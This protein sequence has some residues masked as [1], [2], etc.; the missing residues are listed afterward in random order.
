M[1]GPGGH[2][3]AYHPAAAG[4][5]RESPALVAA[6]KPSIPPT[7]RDPG[8]GPRTPSPYRAGETAAGRSCGRR[9]P[10]QNP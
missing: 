9:K 10:H 3:P 6:K 8:D 4:L 2:Q 7:I 5:Q 1:L